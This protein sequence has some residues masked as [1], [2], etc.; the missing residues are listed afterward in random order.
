M[1]KRHYDTITVTI[2]V[3]MPTH[4]Y[5]GEASLE[6]YLVRAG[7]L[8]NPLCPLSASMMTNIL[9]SNAMPLHP[10]ELSPQRQGT[11]ANGRALRGDKRTYRPLKTLNGRA[12]FGFCVFVKVCE[13]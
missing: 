3:G 10:G 13:F 9:M 8:T 11:G 4:G 2:M 7:P 1:G 12:L 5:L 6:S